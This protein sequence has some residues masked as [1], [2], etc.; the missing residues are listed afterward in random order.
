MNDFECIGLSG[1]IAMVCKYGWKCASWYVTFFTS[2]PTS[3]PDSCVTIL[4]TLHQMHAWAF[5]KSR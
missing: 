1:M 5:R 4:S 3:E 2:S